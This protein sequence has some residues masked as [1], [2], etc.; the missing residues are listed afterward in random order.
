VDIEEA[1]AD[2]AL[3]TTIRKKSKK[4]TKNT[5]SSTP[6]P[7]TAQMPPVLQSGSLLLANDG[8]SGVPPS[9][10]PS[11]SPTRLT[12]PTR[13]AH[14]SWQQGKE[15]PNCFFSNFFERQL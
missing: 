7:S 4:S 12:A 15:H 2:L 11:T 9:T 3:T 14:K 5:N 13:I 10:R 8:A 6:R 1:V